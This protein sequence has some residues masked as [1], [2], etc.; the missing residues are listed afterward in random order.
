MF[1]YSALEQHKSRASLRHPTPFIVAS[2]SLA[3][4]FIAADARPQ[5]PETAVVGFFCGIPQ[6]R[7]WSRARL[8]LNLGRNPRRAF[9]R[10]PSA[11]VT[12]I[13]PLTAVTAALCKAPCIPTTRQRGVGV[14]GRKRSPPRLNPRPLP[15]S[16]RHPASQHLDRAND[17]LYNQSN[18]FSSRR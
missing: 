4:R 18:V 17:S 8:K 7:G 15:F 12:S 1:R 14:A 2:T 5:R 16:Q 6:R 9:S 13:T 11:A 10:H 3:A